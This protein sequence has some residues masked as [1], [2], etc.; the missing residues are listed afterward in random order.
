MLAKSICKDPE[1]PPPLD[2]VMAPAP[3]PVTEDVVPMP[4]TPGPTVELAPGLEIIE[5]T[6]NPFE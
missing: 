6:V 5:P 3:E 4:I 1:A 2:N